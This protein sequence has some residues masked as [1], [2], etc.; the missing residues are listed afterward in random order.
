MRR[1]GAHP[2][3]VYI[4]ANKAGVLYTG[5]TNDLE[6]RIAE[7]KS[8]LIRGFTER[9]RIEK[10]VYF[11]EYE[12]ADLAIAREKQIKGW[13]RGKKLALVESINRDWNDLAAVSEPSNSLPVRDSSLR[14]E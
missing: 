11:E 13:L 1:Q 9:Y 8:H 6:R 7:H 12:Y 2:Y 5:V 4:L 3:F 14:S 10:L